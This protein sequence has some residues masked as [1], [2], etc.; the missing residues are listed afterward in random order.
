[1]IIDD[2]D[3]IGIAVLPDKTDAPLVIDADA[4]LA[5]TVPGQFLEPI[6]RRYTQV[7]QRLRSVEHSQLSERNLLNVLRQ[8]GRTLTVEKQLGV[9]VAKASDH[10]TKL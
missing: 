9:S 2:F 6:R 3:V 10:V 1:M 7:V 5:R 8:P 4:V